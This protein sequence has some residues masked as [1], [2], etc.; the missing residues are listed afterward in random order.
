MSTRPPKPS[1]RALL[2]TAPPQWLFALQGK[3]I[4]TPSPA[5][6]TGSGRSGVWM[7]SMSA[8]GLL[9]AWDNDAAEIRAGGG[10]DE[11]RDIYFL[12]LRYVFHTIHTVSY[13]PTTLQPLP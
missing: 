7:R 8:E 12:Y 4:M 10:R 1:T 11:A 13:V 9:R 5:E 6:T 2:L 3:G